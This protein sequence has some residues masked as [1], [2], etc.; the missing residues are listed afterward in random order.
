MEPVS[1]REVLAAATGV[2]VAAK[3][4]LTMEQKPPRLPDDLV[5]EFVIAAHGQPDKTKSM[6]SEHPELLNA[7]WDW[8]GG[9]F[10][11]AIA[12]SG[13][14]ATAKSPSSSSTR[15]P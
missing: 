11:L 2:L 14:S 8:G 6:L 10:E 7:C 1:R 5:K 13:T 4:P 15:A 3:V 9:D 12:G